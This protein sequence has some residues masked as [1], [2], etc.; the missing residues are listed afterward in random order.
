MLRKAILLGAF[1][2]G[3]TFF[4]PPQQKKD[5]QGFT[6]GFINSFSAI[7]TLIESLYDY[8]VELTKYEYNTEEYHQQRSIIHQRVA[9]RILRLSIENKGVYLKAGQYIGNLERV[10]P[11]EFTQTLRVLQDQGPQVSFEDVKI[12]LEYEFQKPIQELFTTFSHKAI[13][14]ASLAQ[15]HQAT[16]DGKD[17]AVKVQFPQLRVQYRYDLMIIHNIAKLCDF[18]VS[19]TSTSQLNFSDLFSTFRKALEKELDFTLEV[20]NAEITRNNFKNNSRIYIPQFYQYSQRVIIMEFI[21][22]VKINDVNKLKNPRECANILIDMFGQMIFKHGHVHCD[23]HPGNI[24]I[25]EQNGKQQLVL[26]DHGFY[27]DID[28][29]MLQ[30]FRCLWNNIA[31]FNYKQVEQY[32]LKLGIKKDHIEFLPLIFFY[33]TISSKKKLGDAFSIEERQ[34]LRNKDLVTLEN[35]NALLRS[36]PPEIMFIIRAANLVGIH[37]ALLGG[38]TRDRLLKFT[39]YSVKNSE[40]SV[41]KQKFEWIKL[42]IALFLFEFFGLIPK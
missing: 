14:A 38:T 18:V 32:A 20:Q 41:W 10:M 22:G 36:M 24:L 27:T 13:A 1:T 40:K 11:R 19:N 30:N 31:K 39:E 8:Q 15:V 12:V 2:T 23:A 5:L 42:K 26:L 29:E 4:M 25:R 9:D 7:K 21:D 28:Q 6:A 33:R 16:Y 3:C 35:I 37:N 34:Y 17:V